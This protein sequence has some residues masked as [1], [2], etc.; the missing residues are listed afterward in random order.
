MFELLKQSDLVTHTLCKPTRNSGFLYESGMCH[1]ACFDIQGGTTVNNCHRVFQVPPLLVHTN[2]MELESLKSRSV[3][4]CIR[5]HKNASVFNEIP[6]TIMP[7]KTKSTFS[8][9]HH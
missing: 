8:R 7:T 3:M 6:V 4:A 9:L 2:R 1:P 5:I